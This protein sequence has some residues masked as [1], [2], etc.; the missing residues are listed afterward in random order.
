MYLF[1]NNSFEICFK[2]PM[3]YIGQLNHL[4]AYLV[5]SSSVCAGVSLNL[6]AVLPVQVPQGQLET[7]A[8]TV[9]TVV[10]LRKP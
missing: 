3:F 10:I 6:V 7:A 2:T 8:S 1:Q 4:I 5:R 9:T